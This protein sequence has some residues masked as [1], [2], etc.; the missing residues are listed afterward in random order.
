MKNPVRLLASLLGAALLAMAAIVKLRLLGSSHTETVMTWLLVFI[1]LDLIALIACALRPNLRWRWV[2]TVL[3]ILGLGAFGAGF[4][5]FGKLR[6]S[7][8]DKAICTP[9][10][11]AGARQVFHEEP[12]RVF[13]A[14]DDLIG[15]R[16]YIK[17]LNSA[18]GEDY[19]E[20]F[21]LRVDFEELAITMDDGRKNILIFHSG[22]DFRTWVGQTP[23]G[24]LTGVTPA[25]Q[26][27]L[28]A[29]DRS[30]GVHVSTPPQGGRFETTWR[31][32]VPAGPF[33]AYYENGQLWAEATYVGGRPV[34]RHVV[35]DRAGKIIFETQFAPRRA[36]KPPR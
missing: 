2:A 20:L 7:S 28:A 5:A 1:G 17:S 12:W 26:A 32:G 35:Y 14:Y 25:Y 19:H 36:E 18:T 8:Q 11:A 23:E 27:W 15:P 24:K 22:G 30:D 31:G 10:I 4:V 21:P 29:R 6:R 16:Q 3:S 13:L 33:R 34:G 9:F